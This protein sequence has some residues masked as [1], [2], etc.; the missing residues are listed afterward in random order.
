MTNRGSRLRVILES[1]FAGDVAANVEYAKACLLDSLM[2]GEAPYASHLLYT[3]VLDDN[4]LGQRHIGMDAGHAW[5]GAAELVVAYTDRGISQ[6]MSERLRLAH[7]AGLPVE[8][9]SLEAGVAGYAAT[10][11]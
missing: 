10:A 4:D 2:R 3:T 7:E 9:R 6:G 8:Y 11:P 1:P 5:V